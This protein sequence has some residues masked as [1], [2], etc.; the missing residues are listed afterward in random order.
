MEPMN[1][2]LAIALMRMDAFK[3]EH[4]RSM[5]HALL[6]CPNCAMKADM[7]REAYDRRN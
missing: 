7:Q 1:P 4:L 5:Q 2:R 6:G 3:M